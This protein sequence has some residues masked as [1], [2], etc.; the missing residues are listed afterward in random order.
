MARDEYGDRERSSSSSLCKL[1]VVCMTDGYGNADT[2]MVVLPTR[3]K[4]VN[5]HQWSRFVFT[6]A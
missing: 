5:H 2:E 3:M 1:V 4:R 6:D